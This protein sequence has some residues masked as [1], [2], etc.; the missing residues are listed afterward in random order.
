MTER[1]GLLRSYW[2]GSKVGWLVDSDTGRELS[3][4]VSSVYDNELARALLRLSWRYAGADLDVGVACPV[5]FNYVEA[6][7]RRMVMKVR[8]EGEL[9]LTRP[10][11]RHVLYTKSCA[12][13]RDEQDVW[14]MNTSA[15]TGK[16]YEPGPPVRTSAV[17]DPGLLRFINAH[18]H[19]GNKYWIAL[20]MP[21]SC[22]VDRL[23]RPALICR[24]GE[25]PAAAVG[26]AIFDRENEQCLFRVWKD[27]FEG[28]T[29]HFLAA[30]YLNY[31][32]PRKP[33]GRNVLDMIRAE[34]EIMSDAR[35]GA[36]ARVI[37]D[38]Y[39][40]R[41]E[42]AAAPVEILREYRSQEQESNRNTAAA[43][44]LEAGVCCRLNDLAGVL[45]RCWEARRNILGFRLALAEKRYDMAHCFASAWSP[46][47]DDDGVLEE[48][49]D[50]ASHTGNA[51]VLCNGI[52]NYITSL[53]EAEEADPD[54]VIDFSDEFI[55]RC[56]DAL[57][58]LLADCPALEYQMELLRQEGF[59]DPASM[60]PV[61]RELAQTELC[62]RIP[63][64]DE[65]MQDMQTMELPWRSG[66]EE[67]AQS[68][69]AA[70][71]LMIIRNLTEEIRAGKEPAACGADGHT[72]G[73][74]AHG[75][76]DFAELNKRVEA[77]FRPTDPATGRRGGWRL[78]TDADKGM[79]GTLKAL[80]GCEHRD[81]N[82]YRMPL[83][84]YACMAPAEEAIGAAEAYQAKIQADFDRRNKSAA[85]VDDRRWK[86]AEALKRISGGA[87][88]LPDFEIKA[89]EEP[90]LK[91]IRERWGR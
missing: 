80:L 88:A 55:C 22:V 64:W 78:P 68:S 40:S 46:R 61:L 25:L 54:A 44:M 16:P 50:I 11:E 32:S 13:D 85:A 37:L 31:E 3:F 77:C 28:G 51:G 23:G 34:L 24:S 5:V 7:G 21:V 56:N 33:L 35:E 38:S 84:I 65:L 41:L 26:P 20:D 59:D 58:T 76:G 74:S 18:A 81:V 83:L 49:K 91:L 73:V 47:I 57:Q 39:W 48:L 6:D 62:R 63:E 82:P 8:A 75:A 52:D 1:K 53:E 30:D 79:L 87:Q 14:Y 17:V 70:H 9:R 29:Q 42:N 60:L 2:T 36:R 27:M 69:M 90:Y 43:K 86:M 4:A 19:L 10:P 72:A 12:P 15:D 89:D 66:E 45:Q 71:P 67:G